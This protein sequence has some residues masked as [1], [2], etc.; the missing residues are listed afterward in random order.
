MTLTE[1]TTPKGPVFGFAGQPLG[2]EHDAA[3][4]APSAVRLLPDLRRLLERTAAKSA[5]LVLDCLTT[6]GHLAREL[7]RAPRWDL[8]P[9][10]A[11]VIA[12]ANMRVSAK[13]HARRLRNLSALGS[14]RF[15]VIDGPE[16]TAAEGE[17]FI[18]A[19]WDDWTRQGRIDTLPPV[20]RLAGFPHFMGAA[21]SGLAR[22]G[23]A[24]L[25]TLSLNGDRVAEDL[26]IGPPSAPLI[27][28]G[29]YSHDLRTYSPGRV[30]LEE[31]LG[32]LAARGCAYVRM[33]RGDEAYKKEAG[34]GDET[35]LRAAPARD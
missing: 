35:V 30:L 24:R 19:K 12:L 5:D 23:R 25:W 11:P 33:G 29:S 26:H 34:A 1:K 21:V 18:R 31:T 13:G 8:E 16:L 9:L 4:S 32:R 14:L 17:R 15:D 2:D 28:M 6:D 22:R 3:L 7:S 20:E 27:Y 10:A